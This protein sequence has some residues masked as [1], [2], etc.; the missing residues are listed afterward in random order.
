MPRVDAATEFDPL[1]YVSTRG[2]APA[3]DFTGALLGG[4]APDNGLYLPVNMPS[5]PEGWQTWSYPQAVAGSLRLFG[6]GETMDLVT[7]AASRFNHPEVAPIVEVDGRLVLE[8]FW[9]PT[10]SFKDH[11]LQVLARLLKRNV[12]RGTVIGA[13]SGDTGAAAIEACKGSMRI[14]MLFP[15]GRVSEFQRRQ[16][17]TVTDDDVVVVAVRGT[18]DN[19]QAMV[20]QTF[21]AI[22]GLLA[23]NSINWARVAAQAGYYLY[24]AARIAE[25]FDVVVPTGNFGNAYSCWV[26]KQMGAPIET[27]V[28]ANNANHE[29]TDLVVMGDAFG[30]E[31][32]STVAP[33]MDIQVPSNLERMKAPLDQEFVAGWVDD[34]EIRATIAE[35]D[36]QHGY[37]LD[38]HTATAWKVGSGHIGARPQL[39][40]ATAHPAKF[41]EVV[42]EA[43]GIRPRLPAGFERVMTAAERLITI[44]A[45]ASALAE[46]I[47]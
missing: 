29:L 20:K 15:E 26:A 14:F 12:G 31:V 19:C 28:L 17:T 9:G 13:T 18:F 46:L 25:P 33:A 4:L 42:M 11:A 3:V 41:P 36:R 16:M 6:A 23:V 43:I 1:Q 24:A 7:D 8:L 30:S 10:L 5:L 44:D 21:A 37:T 40:V 35:V 32:V 2:Q 27:I 47:R 34:D 39:V 38:P 22:P 45:D